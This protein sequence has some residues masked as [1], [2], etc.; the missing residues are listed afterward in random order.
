MFDF[1][2]EMFLEWDDIPSYEHLAP[3]IEPED[4]YSHIVP[5]VPGVPE[6][7]PGNPDRVYFESSGV[8]PGHFA[9]GLARTRHIVPFA[10]MS[11]VPFWVHHIGRGLSTLES[12]ESSLSRLDETTY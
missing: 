3:D 10:V 7:S 12:D 11:T 1:L 5:D 6:A 9:L 8:S 2:L 4:P